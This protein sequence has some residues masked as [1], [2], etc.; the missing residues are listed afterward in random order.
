MASYPIPPWLQGV[1]ASELGQLTAG[2]LARKQQL[3]METQRLA[4][5]SQQANMQLQARQQQAEQDNLRAQQEM[6]MQQAY[7]QATIGLRKSELDQEQQKVNMAIG[8]A[9]QKLQSQRAMQ[10]EAAQ[11]TASGVPEEEAYMKAALHHGIASGMT[12]SE[13]G[14]FERMQPKAE[15]PAEV[16]NIQGNKFLKVPSSG[17]PRYQPI[18]DTEGRQIRM[19][20]INLIERRLN[21]LQ[22]AHEKDM[23]G[24]TA[25]STNDKSPA[26]SSA[27]N[28]YQTR[29]DEISKL[30]TQLDS[31]LT[32]SDRGQDEP[33]TTE[34]TGT[35]QPT[36]VDG[37]VLPLPKTK[38]DLQVGGVYKTMRGIAKWDGESFIPQ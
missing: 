10:Q 16:V 30:S 33:A 21:Q 17:G 12:G 3:A 35:S 22:A 4:Q 9:T 26:I 34:G 31:M 11:L 18:S 20:R 27:R 1:S 38:R 23:L 29:A 36:P 24:A 32:E 13:F 14:A 2:A 6:T 15:A 19:N 28:R 37:E 7:Q 8:V 5:Q 25:A